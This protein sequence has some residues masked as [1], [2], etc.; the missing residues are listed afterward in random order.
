M[1]INKKVLNY[2]KGEDKKR[3]VTGEMLA[4]KM[5]SDYHNIPEDQIFFEIG[6]YGKPFAVGYTEF[7]L[8]HSDDKVVCC[9]SDKPIG[10]DVEKSNLLISI[11]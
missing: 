10:I 2:R 3:T 6:E 7:N 1:K 8:S 4:R 11:L 5:L 9:I